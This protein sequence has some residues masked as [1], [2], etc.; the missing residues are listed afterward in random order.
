M[1]GN[2]NLCPSESIQCYPTNRN[3]G[4]DGF[5]GE[6]YYTFRELIPI[7]LEVVQQIQERTLATHSM[8]PSHT[9]A[10]V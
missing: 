4:P 7:L 9:D 2:S 6:F 8:R 10:K 5:T 1:P 3:P